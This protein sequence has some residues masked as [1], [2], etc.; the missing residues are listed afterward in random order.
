MNVIVILTA[1]WAILFANSLA[2][3]LP[4]TGFLTVFKTKVAGIHSTQGVL[5]EFWDEAKKFGPKVG[6]IVLDEIVKVY[7]ETAH[8]VGTLKSAAN[9]VVGEAQQLRNELQIIMEQKNI[10]IEHLSDV[11]SNEIG[12]TYM[13]LIRDNDITTLPESRNERAQARAELIDKVLPKVGVAYIRTTVKLGVPD[14][15]A[16]QQFQR[17]SPKVKHILLVTGSFIDDHP[18]LLEFVIFSASVL[19]LP[20]IQI[21]RP[22]MSMFGFGPLGPIKGTTAAWLQSRFWG[23]FVK[24]GS[25][26]AILQKISM[27]LTGSWIQRV[28][29]SAGLA[30]AIGL[31][32]NK[33]TRGCS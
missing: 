2:L 22:I 30:A 29:A 28:I 20:E 13:E 23:G 5:E 12:Q 16:E 32:T 24:S 1:F 17:V 10:T 15:Q 33:I 31:V 11:L 19:L 14:E 3:S 21:L 4:Q 26:F 9:D 6:Q 7:A 25:W 27:T 8:V 18:H